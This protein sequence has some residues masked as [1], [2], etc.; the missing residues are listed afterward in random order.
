MSVGL[1]AFHSES[2]GRVNQIEGV[3]FVLADMCKDHL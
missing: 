2:E 1:G 3:E